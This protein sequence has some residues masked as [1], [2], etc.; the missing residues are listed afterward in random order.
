METHEQRYYE[1]HHY[2]RA[3]HGRLLETASTI[4]KDSG[5]YADCVAALDAVEAWQDRHFKQPSEA[6]VS[7]GEALFEQLELAFSADNAPPM[8]DFMRQGAYV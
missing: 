3:M 8:F 5:L 2:F 4:D 1:L 7:E 6:C